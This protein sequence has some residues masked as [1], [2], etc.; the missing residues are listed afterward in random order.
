MA[1]VESLGHSAMAY[2]AAKSRL[3]RKFGGQRRQINLHLEE[4]DQF[5]PIRPG[6]AKDLDRLAD[7]V[8]KW[9]KSQS[10]SQR[11]ACLQTWE[12]EIT[13]HIVLARRGSNS[14]ILNTP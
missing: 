13:M 1:A 11:G 3:E 6:N 10:E 2:E 8:C 14:P 4:L 5:R 12:Q 9:R 7:L